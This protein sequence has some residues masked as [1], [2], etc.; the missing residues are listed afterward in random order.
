MTPDL[1]DSTLPSRRLN[2]I[3]LVGL[4]GSGKTTVGK[5]V[6]QSIGFNFVDTDDVITRAAGKSIPEIFADEGEAGFRVHETNA[7]RQLMNEQQ[8]VIATGGG[9]VTQPDNLPLLKELGYVVWL[10]ATPEILH[11]RT[12]HS[13]ERPL[14]RNSDPAGTLR[15]LLDAR[16]PLYQQACDLKI[17]TDDLSVHDVAYGLA[18]SVRVAFAQQQAA[19]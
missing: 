12:A 8:C 1:Q 13:D 19:S 11:A 14:L 5:L 2:N 15:S 9:I 17:T 4:M 18:E 10:F 7:L 6:A 3:V 16:A